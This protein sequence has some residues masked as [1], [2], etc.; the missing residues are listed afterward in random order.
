MSLALTEQAAQA[1]ADLSRRAG[2]TSFSLS[3]G[4]EDGKVVWRAVAEMPGGF[5]VGAA[6]S[7]IIACDKL[8]VELL[9]GS[10]CRRCNHV[11]ALSGSDPTLCRYRRRGDRWLPGCGLPVDHSRAMVPKR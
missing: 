3:Y 10:V 5:K 4:N 1:A 9:D 6:H 2:A 8:A 7:P 11:V